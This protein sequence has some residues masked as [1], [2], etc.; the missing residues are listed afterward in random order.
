MLVQIPTHPGVKKLSP[1]EGEKTDIA[2]QRIVWKV[3]AE[4]TDSAFSIYELEVLPGEG[5]PVHLHPYAEIFYVLAGEMSFAHYNSDREEWITAR[6]GDTV[7]ATMRS[8]HAFHNRSD[9]PA[10]F[11]SVSSCLHEAFF[12]D[13][14]NRPAANDPPPTVDAVTLHQQVQSADRY[15]IIFP[16]LLGL[17]ADAM[18]RSVAEDAARRNT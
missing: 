9:R 3:T 4:D 10:R 18:A 17:D 6:A 14:G 11:L 16:F 7:I 1:D 8:L 2:T 15:G 12:R 13:V 5:I